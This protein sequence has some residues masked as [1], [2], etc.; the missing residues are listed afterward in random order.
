MAGFVH[1][2]STTVLK[3]TPYF[4]HCPLLKLRG[5]VPPGSII[6]DFASW[7]TVGNAWFARMAVEALLDMAFRQG[8]TPD[9]LHAV[10]PRPPAVTT[11]AS[12]LAIPRNLPHAE[13]EVTI[14]MCVCWYTWR[15]VCRTCAE[16]S[17]D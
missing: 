5:G 3:K 13:G 7:D 2:P 6:A 16:F 1:C 4:V 8:E 9:E 10:R 15:T 17:C 14:G 12:V 11:N